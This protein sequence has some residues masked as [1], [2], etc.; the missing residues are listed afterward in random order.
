[1]ADEKALFADGINSVHTIIPQLAIPQ[2]VYLDFDGA[3]ASYY[4]RD[5]GIVVSDIA[6]ED[7]GFDDDAIS[8]IVSTLNEQFGDDI[9]FTSSKPSA[10]ISAIVSAMA[11]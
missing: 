11:G 7:S 3:S 1:M 8:V 2:L 4:N 5:L 10:S 6:I 9:V